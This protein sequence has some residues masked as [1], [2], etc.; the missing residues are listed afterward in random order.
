M[1]VMA[2]KDNDPPVLQEVRMSRIVMLAVLLLILPGCTPLIITS[3]VVGTTAKVAVGAAKVPVKVAGA[4]ID[5][6]TP[7]GDEDKED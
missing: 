5:V 2:T 1:T 3:A 4:A 7:D 6:A